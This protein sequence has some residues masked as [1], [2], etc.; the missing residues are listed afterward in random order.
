[1]RVTDTLKSTKAFE[2]G[3]FTQPQAE[4]LAGQQEDT[5][6]DLVANIGKILEPRFAGIDSKFAELRAEIHST[7]RDQLFKLMTFGVALA[8]LCLAAGGFMLAI[9][10]TS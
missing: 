6:Q 9:L 8:G 5:A 4:V 1:M 10:R 2:A 3:G 7:A